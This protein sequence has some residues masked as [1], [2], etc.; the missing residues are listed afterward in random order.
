[1]HHFA[2]WRDSRTVRLLL[3]LMTCVTFA[4]HDDDGYWSPQL[5][6]LECERDARCDGV[7]RGDCAA[8]C[9]GPEQAPRL[10]PRYVDAV[11]S[12]LD[13]VG[14]GAA[15][16]GLESEACLRD[17]ARRLP[18]SKVAEDL[19][20][21]ARG[22]EPLCGGA[23]DPVSCLDDLKILEDD[24]LRRARRCFDGPCAERRACVSR[25][26]GPYPYGVY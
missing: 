6:R 21:K 24:D 4:C 20:R 14:C 22:E 17:E 11:R 9:G 19:C 15:L 25:A 18:P 3:A 1:F 10:S 7:P 5:C 23:L 16:V 13:A 12:C 2:R 26:L 8:R